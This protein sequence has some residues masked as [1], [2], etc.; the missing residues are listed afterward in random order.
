MCNR[1]EFSQSDIESFHWVKFNGQNGEV[2]YALSGTIFVNMTGNSPSWLQLPVTCKIDLPE[3]PPGQGLFPLYWT[4]FASLNSI[5]DK[6][7]ANNGGHGVNSFNLISVHP[8]GTYGSKDIT[9]SL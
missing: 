3:L 7:V 9:L 5:F 4:P 1:T 2:L 8:D 6:D